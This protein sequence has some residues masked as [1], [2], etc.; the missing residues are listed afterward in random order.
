MWTFYKMR[1]SQDH[2]RSRKDVGLGGKVTARSLFPQDFAKGTGNFARLYRHSQMCR[3]M[4]QL[5]PKDLAFGGDVC[6]DM[7][8]IQ[9]GSWIMRCAEISCLPCLLL[10]TLL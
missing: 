5:I 3:H 10:K 1:S 7:R 8:H 6:S 4:C 9:G 2:Q